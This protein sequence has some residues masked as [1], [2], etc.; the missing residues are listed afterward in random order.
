MNITSLITLDIIKLSVLTGKV[1]GD[2]AVVFHEYEFLARMF[3]DIAI[4]HCGQSL[5]RKNFLQIWK[6]F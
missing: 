3:S 1:L 4:V 2:D 5:L 6:F